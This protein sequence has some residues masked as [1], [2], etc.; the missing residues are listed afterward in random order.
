MVVCGPDECGHT[1]QVKRVVAEAG[2]SEE[3]DFKSSVYGAE[4][5]ALYASADLFVLPT[6][7]ENFGVAIAE[8]LAA[9]V[10]VITT[11]G[12]PVGRTA[13]ATMRMVD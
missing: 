6:F 12:T 1:E 13:H 2:L 11:T 3:F 8:A 7:S 4:K 9:E 5:D 10:P